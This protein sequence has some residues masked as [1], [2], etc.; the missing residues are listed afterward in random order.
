MIY[1]KFDDHPVADIEGFVGGGEVG[2]GAAAAGRGLEHYSLLFMTSWTNFHSS[3]TWNL[4]WMGP[5]A[6]QQKMFESIHV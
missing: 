2:V 4:V 1:I 5:V 6:L 3:S